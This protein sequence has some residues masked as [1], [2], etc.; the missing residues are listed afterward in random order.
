MHPSL[1]ECNFYRFIVTPS[2]SIHPFP[3]LAPGLR[4][5]LA[6]Y[7]TTKFVTFSFYSKRQTR[8]NNA[9]AS[10]FS[11]R[12]NE[13]AALLRRVARV[14]KEREEERQRGKKGNAR[15]ACTTFLDNSGFYCIIAHFPTNKGTSQ[16]CSDDVYRFS[17]FERRV[18]VQFARSVVSCLSS[19]VLRAVFN[20]DKLFHGFVT[21]LPIKTVIKLLHVIAAD[22]IESNAR[23]IT[24]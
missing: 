2:S 17:L 7:F 15:N 11:T 16:I 20:S 19:P 12:E 1:G 13:D 4:G 23:S 10:L 24:I 21:V 22:T 9:N 6:I 5:G 14:K 8:Q 18:L 3:P